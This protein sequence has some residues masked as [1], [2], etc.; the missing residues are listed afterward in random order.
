MEN[1]IFETKTKSDKKIYFRY[2][3]IDDVQILMDFIDKISLEK[4]I[5]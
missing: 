4:T 1:I 3:T 5:G 2:P